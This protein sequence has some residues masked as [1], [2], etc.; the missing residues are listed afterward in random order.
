MHLRFRDEEFKLLSFFSS[1]K[2]FSLPVARRF[3]SYAVGEA[4][5]VNYVADRNRF[6]R[7][8]FNSVFR[9]QSFQ[10]FVPAMKQ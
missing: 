4:W 7:I 6:S 10:K 9:K 2:I 3:T 1:E 8:C 5:L